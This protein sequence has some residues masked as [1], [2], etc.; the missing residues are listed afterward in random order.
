MDNDQVDDAKETL[1]L[2]KQGDYNSDRNFYIV[3]DELINVILYL[4]NRI[5]FLERNGE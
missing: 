4:E 3:I 5:E 2:I 1:E